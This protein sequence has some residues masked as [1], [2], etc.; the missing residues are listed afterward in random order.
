M[1]WTSPS[2]ASS[3]TWNINDDSCLYFNEVYN[4]Y[5]NT[6]TK[7]K[8]VYLLSFWSTKKKLK[9]IAWQVVYTVFTS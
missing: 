4:I 3:K 9:A 1:S 2:T 8:N 6:N 5:T 7:Y